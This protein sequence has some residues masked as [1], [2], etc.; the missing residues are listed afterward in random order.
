[1]AYNG[2]FKGAVEQYRVALQLEPNSGMTHLAFGEM[3]I[4]HGMYSQGL[5]ELQDA[6]KFLQGGASARLLGL[7][8]YAY[9]RMGDVAKAGA[10]LEQLLE[11]E[12][13]SA[14]VGPALYEAYVYIGLGDKDR[15][16]RYLRKAT[17]VQRENSLLLLNVSPLYDS[18]RSDP[19][20]AQLRH[21]MGL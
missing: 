1:M 19:R 10:I 3:Y 6:G 12:N 11:R 7:R 5:S 13:D 2:N 4:E 21:E 17:T 20:L 15:A 8:G 16:F 9:G 18:L 14:K